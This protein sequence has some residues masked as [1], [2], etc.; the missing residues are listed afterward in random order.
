MKELCSHIETTIAKQD[1]FSTVYVIWDRCGLLQKDKPPEVRL[2]ALIATKT[3]PKRA[4]IRKRCAYWKEGAGS[5]C[6][7]V[8]KI[9]LSSW[10][11]GIGPKNS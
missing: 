1:H 6:E 4:L 2:C 10:R 8:K 9:K 5:N 3:Y 7:I 11:T